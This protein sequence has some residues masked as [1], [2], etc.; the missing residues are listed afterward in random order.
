M[1]YSLKDGDYYTLKDGENV[2][3]QIAVEAWGTCVWRNRKMMKTT[4]TATYGGDEK[5]EPCDFGEGFKVSLYQ[6]SECTEIDEEIPG[7]DIYTADR[8]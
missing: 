5:Q 8:P 2:G 7:E 4:T 6:D 3:D 1:V